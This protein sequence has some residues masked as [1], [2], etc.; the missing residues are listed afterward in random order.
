MIP[1][2]RHILKAFRIYAQVHINFSKRILLCLKHS[3]GT[4]D[5]ICHAIENVYSGRVFPRQF[6]DNIWSYAVYHTVLEKIYNNVCFS[7]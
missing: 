2:T 3:V 5:G 1:Y 6:A 4:L 7:L